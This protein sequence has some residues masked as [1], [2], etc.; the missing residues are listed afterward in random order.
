MKFFEG[1]GKG[2]FRRFAI[3]QF[4][5]DE[6]GDDFCI[7]FGFKFSLP[8]EAFAQLQKILDNPIMDHGD[9]S[10]FMG[11]GIGFIR[12]TVGRP[13]CMGDP[14]LSVQRIFG[15]ISLEVFDFSLS[16]TAR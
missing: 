11:V 6:M 7:C 12:Y 10:G 15:N 5:I 9:T 4:N 14:A 1:S 16:A 2:L 3:G 8:F 13:S